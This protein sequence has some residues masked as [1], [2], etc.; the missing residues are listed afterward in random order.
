[1]SPLGRDLG[2]LKT[3]H[4]VKKEFFRDGLKFNI[5]KF[6]AECLVFKQNKVEKFKTQQVLEALSI[7]SQCWEEVSMDLVKGLRK[8][9]GKS[10]I[11]VVVNRLT[12]Y[13]HFFSLS[14]PFKTSTT[15][16]IFI[17]TIQKLHG[18]PKI[19]VDDIYVV[20]T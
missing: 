4:R 2:F 13:A 5:Q 12:R 20:S 15:A 17:E 19:I 10:V 16:I 9:E 3:F 14:H 8:S 7:P 11:M 1:L 6:V 18:N